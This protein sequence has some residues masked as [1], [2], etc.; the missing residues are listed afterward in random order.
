MNRKEKIVE[1]EHYW[2][3]P[4]TPQENLVAICECGEELYREVDNA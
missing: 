1:H 2:D 4:T 3:T